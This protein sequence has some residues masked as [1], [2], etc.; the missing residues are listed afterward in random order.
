MAMGYRVPALTTS[1]VVRLVAARPRPS[2][3]L[4]GKEGGQWLVGLC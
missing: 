3:P 1:P 4:G 2:N